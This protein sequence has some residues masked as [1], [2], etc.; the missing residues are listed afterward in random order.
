MTRLLGAILAGGQSRRF[1][2]DKAL[3]L[4]AGRSLIDHAIDALAG[5]VE[6]VIVVGRPPDRAGVTTIPDRPSPGLGPLGG[7]NAALHHARAKGFDAVVSIGCD[8]PIL[9]RDLVALLRA[10]GRPSFLAAMPIA[11]YWPADLA[12]RLDDHLA[13]GVE[14]SMRGWARVVDATAIALPT[15]L[16]NINTPADLADLEGR[17]SQSDVDL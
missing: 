11:G 2:E 9:P 12:G 8:T 13:S 15:E 1:G 16:P 3:A 4:L 6:Q 5:Q 17:N 14:R 7:L 10:A